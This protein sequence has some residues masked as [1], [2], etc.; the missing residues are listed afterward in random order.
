MAAP[1]FWYH[2]ALLV[3]VPALSIADQSIG[4]H[5][6]EVANPIVDGLLSIAHAVNDH[7]Y[8]WS[9]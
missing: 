7:V 2:H 8:S 5:Q 3:I 4:P 6:P 1:V 9:I